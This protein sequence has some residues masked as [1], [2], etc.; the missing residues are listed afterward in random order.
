M[1]ILNQCP[2]CHNKNLSLFK[3]IKDHFYSKESF[4]LYQC[5]NCGFIFT[6]PRPEIGNLKMY[7]QSE[8]YLSHSKNQRNL[9]SIIYSI[10]KNY[11]LQKKYMIISKYH[12]SGKVLDIGCA[13]GE[14]L[15]YFKQKGWTTIGIEPA[16]N[17]R[18]YATTKYGL[19]VYDEPKLEN[20]EKNTFDVITLWHVLEHVPD[21]SHR[22]EQINKL[23][24]K[25]GVI[26]IAL[27]NYNS[28]DAKHYDK[29]W[30]AYDVPRHLSHFSQN[31]I[32]FLLEQFQLKI[33]ETIP[34]KFDA[35]YVSLLSEKYKSGR[36][37]YFKAFLNGFKSNKYG[38]K[39]N[40]NY[41]S[42]IYMAKKQLE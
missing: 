5:D 42:L 37:N 6:N 13:T 26:A 7:Y 41:S 31:T 8:E 35:Y 27:P 18:K 19:E 29:H 17:P 32:R 11:S 22:M 16:E 34:L 21:L 20:L 12:R 25:D 33:I 28:W 15:N 30:A 10:I 38:S 39:N 9:T 3:S 40:M 23:L 4:D 1:D 36:M 14:F 24:K 2:V